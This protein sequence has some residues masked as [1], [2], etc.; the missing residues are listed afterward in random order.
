MWEQGKLFEVRRQLGSKHLIY[1]VETTALKLELDYYSDLAEG[2]ALPE[3][4]DICLDGNWGFKINRNNF[5]PLG[6]RIVASDRLDP[7]FQ[8]ML[9]AHCNTIALI[10]PIGEFTYYLP[11]HV[12]EAVDIDE[13]Q[14]VFDK[15][16]PPRLIRLDNLV[17]LEKATRDVPIFR[18]FPPEY[19]TR[20]FVNEE[21]VDLYKACGCKGLS[22]K[23][24]EVSPWWEAYM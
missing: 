10:T 21:F 5:V 23:P 8:N 2:Y 4:I 19:S 18:L 22:F 16:Q 12:I 20:N 15:S 1:D 17:L 24:V 6:N 9:R 13:T 11:K 3:K 7:Q 14:A